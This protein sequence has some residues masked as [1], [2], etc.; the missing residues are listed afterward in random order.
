MPTIHRERGYKFHFW[1]GEVA[2]EPP[3]VHIWGNEGEIKV[4]LNAGLE[5]EE[6][7]NIPNHEQTK[8]L[9]TIKEHRKEFLEKWYEVK[10]RSKKRTK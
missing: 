7:Y 4:W 3:H 5:I 9:K 10:K 2:N 6:C 1:V 8:L